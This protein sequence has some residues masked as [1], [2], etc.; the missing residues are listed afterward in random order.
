MDSKARLVQLHGAETAAR[1]EAVDRVEQLVA[2]GRSRL[3]AQR[4]VEIEEGKAHASRARRHP[5]SRG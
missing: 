4:M 1:I 2:Q 5:L 3:T